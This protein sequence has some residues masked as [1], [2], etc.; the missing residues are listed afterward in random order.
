MAACRNVAVRGCHPKISFQRLSGGEI[1][2][3]YRQFR[4]SVERHQSL[5]NDSSRQGGLLQITRKSFPIICNAPT[6]P[7]LGSRRCIAH[8][9]RVNDIF[10]ESNA[11][12]SGKSPNLE[13]KLSNGPSFEDFLANISDGSKSVPASGG[14]PYLNKSLWSGRGK[15]GIV[16]TPIG[17]TDIGKST[18]F[19]EACLIIA[20]EHYKAYFSYEFQRDLRLDQLFKPSYSLKD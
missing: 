3:S 14:V 16:V 7:L 12:T 9:S 19:T 15:K 13:S 1:R 17:I 18:L 20:T 8:G 11:R 2:I 6:G 5:T 10:E 4:I